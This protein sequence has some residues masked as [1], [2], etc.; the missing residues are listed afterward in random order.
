MDFFFFYFF[1]L[2]DRVSVLLDASL[3]PTNTNSAESNG[4]DSTSSTAITIPTTPDSA[5]NGDPT[6]L[7]PIVAGQRDRFRQRN[8]ELDVVSI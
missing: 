6:G 5:L 8:T 7:L 1:S 3:S 4:S 2:S